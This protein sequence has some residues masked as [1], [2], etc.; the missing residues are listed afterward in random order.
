MQ[1]S[2][3][4]Q[5]AFLLTCKGDLT[6]KQIAAHLGISDRTLRNWTRLSEW[7][8]RENEA[9]AVWEDEWRITMKVRRHEDRARQEAA[10]DA[11]DAA[12]Q[13]RMKARY[14]KLWH[15]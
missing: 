5:A 9:R 2:D 10:L 14:G 6:Q 12:F 8:D 15:G 4:I 1:W 7:K 3:K 11:D 13:K